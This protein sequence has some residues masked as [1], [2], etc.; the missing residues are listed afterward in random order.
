MKLLATTIAVA[1]LVSNVAA[2]AGQAKPVAPSPAAQAPAPS[3]P[4]GTPGVVPALV[5]PP[6]DYVISAGD[7]LNVVYCA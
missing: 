7:V 2:V 1:L 4:G 6:A 3:V 5:T